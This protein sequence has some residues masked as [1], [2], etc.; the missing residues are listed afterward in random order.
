MRRGTELLRQAFILTL[1]LPVCSCG[2]SVSRKNARGLTPFQLAS[3]AAC[4]P[5]VTLLA[6]QTG[7]ALLGKLVQR[8]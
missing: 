3:D 2:A 7:L 5:M 1:L 6:A 4:S 8:K